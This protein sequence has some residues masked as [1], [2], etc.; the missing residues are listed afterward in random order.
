MTLFLSI[1][2]KVEVIVNG[3]RQG[4]T[5]K[6]W[7]TPAGKLFISKRGLLEQYLD[8]VQVKYPEIG[9]EL[10]IDVGIS[11]KSAKNAATAYETAWKYTKSFIFKQWTTKPNNLND[12][13]LES[14]KI[15][16]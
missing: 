11:Y 1:F 4:I 6:K 13:V 15:F 8:V 7:N 2:R 9:F 14:T 16:K 12:F 10:G 5:K 3:R